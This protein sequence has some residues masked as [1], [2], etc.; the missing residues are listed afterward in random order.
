M[1]FRTAKITDKSD[2]IKLWREC[3]LTRPWNAPEEDFDFALN[4]PASSVLVLETTDRI[5]GSALVGNDGHRGTVYYVSI[6]PD[7]QN[8]GLGKTLMDAAEDWLRERGVWKVNL[9]VRRDNRAA[10]SFYEKQGYGDQDC[11][12]LG[13][14]LDGRADRSVE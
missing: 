1:Q 11:I 7:Y 2:V 13:K 12:A 5:V 10:V 4:G 3:G 6:A 8:Q 9:L 14:R